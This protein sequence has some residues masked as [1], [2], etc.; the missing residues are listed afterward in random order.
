LKDTKQNNPRKKSIPGKLVER[1]FFVAALGIILL[2]LDQFLKYYFIKHSYYYSLFSLHLIKNT[3]MSFGLLPNKVILMIIVSVLFLGLLWWFRKEF[4]DCKYCFMFLVIGT[5][6]NLI[7]RI[8]R[9]YVVDF[10]DLGWFPVFNLSDTLITL[11]T[12]GIVYVFLTDLNGELCGTAARLKE[13]RRKRREN[14]KLK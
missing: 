13:R 7:D 3:G 10:F 5:I 4:R 2:L 1:T 12:M 6:G 14:R 9:G 11:G 8:L